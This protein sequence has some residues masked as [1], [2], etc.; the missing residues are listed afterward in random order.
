[1]YEILE[2]DEIEPIKLSVTQMYDYV[3]LGFVLRNPADAVLHF[4]LANKALRICW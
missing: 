4:L 3:K 2:L 1:M